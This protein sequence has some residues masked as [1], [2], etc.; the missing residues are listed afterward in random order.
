MHNTTDG[1]GLVLSPWRYYANSSGAKKISE[2]FEAGYN[3]QMDKEI[4]DKRRVIVKK[5]WSI[6]RLCSPHS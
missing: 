5:W 3:F 6:H 2:V 4:A 1:K